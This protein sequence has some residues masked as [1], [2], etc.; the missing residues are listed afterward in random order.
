M[1][2]VQTRL[3]AGTIRTPGRIRRDPG[4]ERIKLAIAVVALALSA[5]MAAAAQQYPTRPIKLIVPDGPGSA[6]DTRARQ[7]GGKLA[8]ALGQPVIVEN[9]PGG[10]MIIGAEAAARSPA[11]GHTL[12]MGNVVT[13]SLSTH[14]FK[15]LPYRPDEDFIPVTMISAGPL[16]MLVNPEFPV[17][18]MAELIALART[19]V[20][21]YGVVAQGSPAHIVMEQIRALTGARLEPV[22]YKTTGQ[23]VQDLI[24][25]HVKVAMTFWS[26]AGTHVEAGRLRALAVAS[27]K[28]LEVA[29]DLPTFAEAGLPGIEAHAWQGIFVPAG[30]PAAIVRRLNAEIARVLKLPEVR[31]PL[32]DTGAEV[33]GNSS[34]EFAAFI[35]ADRARWKKAVSDARIEPQN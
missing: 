10:S 4:E 30:T 28:R 26:V 27:A 34:E 31:A 21:D 19:R 9:R 5:A 11:D 16:V 6:P 20:L 15:S 8:E 18:S 23:Y 3:R 12:F 29:P 13:H 25:G 33:G 14:L 24:A 2:E 1:E 35:R 7:I 32:V 17:K 22:I